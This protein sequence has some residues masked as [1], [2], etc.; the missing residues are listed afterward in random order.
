MK[1]TMLFLLTV[2]LFALLACGV[3]AAALGDVD[4]DGEITAADARLALRRAVELEDYAPGSEAFLACDAD[5]DDAVTAADA[6][7]IL[8]AA[9][10][11]EDLSV[12]LPESARLDAHALTAF[13]RE[14]TLSA[15]KTR[16]DDDTEELY[17]LW[18]G[19]GNAVLPYEE[20]ASNSLVEFWT[21]GG[22]EEVAKKGWTGLDRENDVLFFALEYEAPAPAILKSGGAAG[23]PVYYV[24]PDASGEPVLHEATFRERADGVIVIAENTRQTYVFGVPVF[25]RFG[26]VLGMIHAGY[27]EESGGEILFAV[28]PASDY[29]GT[30]LFVPE[31]D[32]SLFCEMQGGFVDFALDEVTLKPG[33]VC[34]LPFTVDA[35]DPSVFSFYLD[36]GKG[37]DLEDLDDEILLLQVWTPPRD[38]SYGL[39][40]ISAVTKGWNVKIRGYNRAEKVKVGAVDV[41][42]SDDGSDFYLG[43]GP[44]ADL[45]SRIGEPPHSVIVSENK[46]S[47]R[48]GFTGLSMQETVDYLNTFV[49]YGFIPESPLPELRE[50]TN[51]VQASYY[52]HN[53]ELGCG[54]LTRIH[55]RPEFDENGALTDVRSDDFDITITFD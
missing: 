2:L 12:R 28:I 41:H 14:I 10:E 30:E 54:I 46:I 37:V 8:R 43:L 13:G 5:Y 53:P 18:L 42:I 39:L 48:Y 16:F 32:D 15:R 35:P 51:T 11:L 17:G 24:L 7:L 1:K 21:F 40:V 3:S 49:A 26:R 31:S 29:L 47:L 36:P 52:F 23:D 33:G 44:I 4:A 55:F 19:E 9:V 27:R 6:R 34:V 50:F 45:G 38:R 22:R 20:A 25:D